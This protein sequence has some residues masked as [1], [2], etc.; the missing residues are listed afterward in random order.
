VGNPGSL[1]EQVGIQVPSCGLAQAADTS[2]NA[3][4]AVAYGGIT[5]QA[6]GPLSGQA[7]GFSGASP[8]LGTVNQVAGPTTFTQL[9]WFNTTTSGSVLGF[10]NNQGV[11]SQSESDRMIWVDPTG[12]VVAGV[13]AGSAQEL[14]SRHRKYNNGAWHLVTVTLSSTGYTLYVDGA[15]AAT[16][17]TAATAS[18][19][20]ASSYNGY[21]H[22]GWSGTVNGWSNP[23]TSAYFGGSLAGVAILPT[24]LTAT[25]VSA[26]YSSASFS[27]YSSSVGNY[28][29]TAY[30]PMQ[31]SG[32][33]PYTG[34]VP[35]SGGAAGCPQVEVTAQLGSTCLYPSSGCSAPSSTG[36]L[37]GLATESPTTA[38]A[39][40]N[41]VSL[42]L[43]YREVSSLPAALSGAHVI[44]TVA[45]DGA[46]GWNVSLSHLANIEL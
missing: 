21:W 44:A 43:A 38:L 45:L 15:V 39:A 37:A 31:D 23:P 25:Q 41:Q 2:T 3:D 20:S 13:Q 11:G 42:T 16:N 19:T 24:A 46:D 12:H 36:T 1:G 10:S 35:S 5:Y 34:T 26:L 18:V 33:A 17:T 40:G 4:T 14:T 9:A 30:W 8:W 27:A 29:P 32:T 22:L 7:I 6:A 28:S